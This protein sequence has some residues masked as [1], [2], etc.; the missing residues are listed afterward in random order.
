[1]EYIMNDELKDI[2]IVLD[3]GELKYLSGFRRRWDSDRYEP[4]YDYMI[5][6]DCMWNEHSLHLQLFKSGVVDERWKVYRLYIHPDDD[7]LHKTRIDCEWIS[8]ALY[9]KMMRKF[10]Y[11]DRW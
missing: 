2:L 4:E 1:M 3:D 5:T 10:N 7:K 11:G 8:N 9:R 6:N